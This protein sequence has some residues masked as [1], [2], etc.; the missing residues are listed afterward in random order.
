MSRR[1]EPTV[2]SVLVA[3]PG[4][5]FPALETG[6]DGEPGVEVCDDA[7]AGSAAAAARTHAAAV[8]RAGRTTADS[9]PNCR[10]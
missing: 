1:I 9:Y 6:D 8:M 10:L 4:A 7:A 2:R 3:D 5:V